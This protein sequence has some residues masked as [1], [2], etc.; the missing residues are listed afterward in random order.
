MCAWGVYRNA[1]EVAV[2]V[3]SFP[4]FLSLSVKRRLSGPTVGAARSGDRK[5]AQRQ[6]GLREGMA[7]ACT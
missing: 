1:P 3:Q 4:S 2:N 7:G 5:G 6:R